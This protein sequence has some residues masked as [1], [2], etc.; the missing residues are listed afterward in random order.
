MAT[1]KAPRY[2]RVRRRPGPCPA[3]RSR[4]FGAAR[5]DRRR[6]GRARG[7][8]GPA[9]VA[10]RA[11]D[12]LSGSAVGDHLPAVWWTP[13][14]T[15]GSR[16]WHRTAARP[17]AASAAPPGSASPA[18]STGRSCSRSPR[19]CSTRRATRARRCRTSPTASACSRAA[20][21]TTSSPR[22]TCSSRSSA[23]CTARATPSCAPP[24]PPTATRFRASRPRS[25]PPSSTPAATS[26]RRG[27]P[28]RAGSRCPTARREQILGSGH[29]YQGVFRDLVAEAQREG[30]TRPDVDPRV[31]GLSI[32]GSTNWVY[33]WFRPDGALDAGGDRR[34]SSRRWPCTGWRP[35]TP[36][37]PG[38]P[39]LWA[40]DFQVTCWSPPPPPP[41]KK[42]RHPHQGTTGRPRGRR[43]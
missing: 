8:R 33:R 22:R 29:A 7:H 1:F 6:P 13:T 11:G 4:K 3:R 2:V 42:K 35:P 30:L 12:R 28:A 10:S 31:A 39:S 5:A 26:S 16:R 19:R 38:V 15:S 40:P 23:R 21:T 36:S 20:S 43:R 14:N 9:A 34:S 37:P 18:R 25:A 27:V 17:G 32:L 41:K 24:R